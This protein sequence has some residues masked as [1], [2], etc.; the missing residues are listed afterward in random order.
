MDD[1][2]LSAE[3]EN[4]ISLVLEGKSIFITGPGG[5]GK[6]FL[7]REIYKALQ[8]KGKCVSVTALTGTAAS[9][10]TDI[11]A[12]TLHSWAGLNIKDMTIEQIL[13]RIRRKK[14]V[15]ERWVNTDVLIID[16]V[17]M[18]P[19]AMAEELDMIGKNIRKKTV[20]KDTPMPFGGIQMVFVGDFFQL[21]PVLTKEEES[22]KQFI[23]EISKEERERGIIP[24]FASSIRSKKQVIVLRKNYRQ[25]HD[26]TFQKILDQIRYGRVTP[27]I[28]SILQS[29]VIKPP[30]GD[31]TP[32]RI[33]STRAQVE[34]INRIEMLKLDSKTERVYKAIT[35]ERVLTKTM[36]SSKDIDDEACAI[37]WAP[38]KRKLHDCLSDDEYGDDDEDA[39]IIKK[40]VNITEERA[41]E[42]LDNGGS[43]LPELTIRLGAQVMITSNLN[44]KTGI[45]NGTRGVVVELLAE[46]IGVKLLDG[47]IVKISPK[48]TGTSHPKIGRRQFPIIPAWA[49]TIHKSQGQ[50]IDYAEIDLGT[51]IFAD[52]QAYVALSRVKSLEGLFIRSFVKGSVRV[53]KTVLG[54]A[55]AIGDV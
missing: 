21:P 14:D 16:E 20:P 40:G 24:P 47:R 3:Q 54:F 19:P 26:G 45:V 50:T 13:R 2:K 15:V 10:M 44:V 52:G 30:E 29:R 43:Y 23:F 36:A 37:T 8:T 31:I 17:S 49:I 35:M 42:E 39:K 55:E 1:I 18:M 5:T 12:R 11:G 32:T 22:K 51:S 48:V 28:C 4:A 38:L 41:V 9:L 53:S 34:D 27:E 7:I 25:I 6:T 46:S 33:L